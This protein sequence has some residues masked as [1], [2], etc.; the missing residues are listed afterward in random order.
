MAAESRKG[1]EPAE[2]EPAD[3]APSRTGANQPMKHRAGRERTSRSALSRTGARK[4]MKHAPKPV[5][6]HADEKAPNLPG[7]QQPF[8]LLPGY[9]TVEPGQKLLCMVEPRP[10]GL[11]LRLPPLDGCLALHL[12]L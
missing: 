11:L 3:E 6:R 10:L 9:W 8:G 2:T 4:P 1:S 12:G 7:S 5:L